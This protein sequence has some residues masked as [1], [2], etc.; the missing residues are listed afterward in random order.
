[1][2]KFLKTYSTYI[3]WVVLA[4]LVWIAYRVYTNRMAKRDAIGDDTQPFIP[5]GAVPLFVYDP[6]K[7]DRNRLF[8][9]GSKDSHEVGY[10]QSWLNQYHRA[11]L[12]VDGNFGPRTLAAWQI[13][14][15]GAGS[16]QISL[17]S[18]KI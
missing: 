6:S 3:Y 16:L 10:L 13:A 12:V 1:M 15:P 2:G 5:G 11:G 14:K 17:N 8:G 7:V 9:L 4:I 18:V